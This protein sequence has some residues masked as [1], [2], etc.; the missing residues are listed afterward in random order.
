MINK[1]ISAV[2]FLIILSAPVIICQ[3]QPDALKTEAKKEMQS[4]RFGEAIDL[5]NRYIS[6]HPQEADG[7]NLRGLCY[8]KRAQYEM[9]VYD[10]RSARKLISQNKEINQ[11]LARTTDAWYKLLYNKIEGHKREIALFPKKAVNYLEI[12]KSYKNLGEW[13]TAEEW[14]DKY[15]ALEEASP[16][17]IIRYTEILAKNNHIAK[18]EPILKRYTDKFPTDQRLWSRY[19]YFELWLGKNKNAIFAFEQALALKPYFK[20]AMDGLDQAKGNGYIYTVNDTSYRYGKGPKGQKPQ[21]YAIDKYFRMLKNKP[22][23]TETRF[24]LID[25]LV[26][27]SR[28]EEASQQLQ[29]LQTN[30]EVANTDRFK[31]KLNFVNNYKDSLYKTTIAQYAERFQ[32]NNNDKEA[33]IKLSNSYEHLYD[34]DNAIDVLDKYLAT[35]K[36]N[37]DLDLRFLLAKY[38]GWSYK[39]D[40][41]FNE[42]AILMKYDPN[43]KAYELFNAQ[44]VGW[45]ILD[46]KPDEVE[47]AKGMLKDVLKDDPNNLPALLSMCYLFAGKG[48]IAE[49]TEYLNKAKIV[50]P[51]SKEVEAIENYIN[52]RALVV[53]EREILDMRGVAGKYYD[54]GNFD[55][56]ANK[57]NEI[58]TKLSSPEKDILLEGAAYNTAAKRYDTAIKLYDK[59][60]Q[61]GPDFGVSSLKAIN[62]LGAGDTTKA[63]QELIALKTQSPYDFNV[64]FH[65]GDTYEKMKRNDDAISLYESLVEANGNKVVNYD[66][67]QINVFQS[68]LNY[69]TT[70]YGSFGGSLLGY[71]SIAPSGSIYS[72]NQDFTFSSFGGR[73]ETGIVT[74]LSIGASYFRYNLSYNPSGFKNGRNLT[75]FL[76]HLLYSEGYFSASAGMGTTRSLFNSQKNVLQLNARYEK[77]ENYGIGFIFEKNDAR[78]LLYSPFLMYSNIYASVLRING[79]YNLPNNFVLSGWFSYINVK[80]DNNA[81][82]DFQIRAGKTVDGSV[83]IGYE[84]YYANYTKKSILYYSP[85]NYDSHSIWADWRAYRDQEIS[86]TIGGKLG[87]VPA[88]DFILRE[89]YGEIVYHPVQILTIS[90]RLSYSSSFRYT[91]SY[92][93]IAGY[94]AAYLAIF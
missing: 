70:G 11:N 75:S 46:A 34:F 53:N 19:G 68:R 80:D 57:Y 20:E 67:S 55:A 21:E 50:S 29:V 40:N 8:E 66:S 38:N 47:R 69:L 23:D 83:T 64:N 72:D 7:Y 24:A 41:A 18:G 82:N 61:F 90:G 12:G 58:L 32:K 25:E 93:F 51:D 5:L 22:G 54:E 52:T 13:A 73:I 56:A 45:N 81:G 76:G 2:I 28:F 44:L 15:L 10:F 74:H 71:I 31:D 88:N 43:N 30:E 49:A 48:N 79:Y 42:M 91:S 14:Y 85:Q 9:S 35:V 86:F 27:H 4:G 1:I 6:A 17:E 16:D 87:Y 37:E 65:L 3:G 77:K 84:Y 60:L 89:I 36:E 63:L 62:Y 92:N 33:A 39:W 59:A 94:L 26:N 78:V